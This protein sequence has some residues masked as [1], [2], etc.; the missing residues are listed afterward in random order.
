MTSIS[1]GG[2]AFH[3]LNR[4]TDKPLDVTNY[5]ERIEDRGLEGPVLQYKMGK[6][7]PRKRYLFLIGKLL[8][9]TK[10]R[11][12]DKF[13]PTFYVGLTERKNVAVV[14]DSQYKIPNVEF[15]LYGHYT[16]ILFAPS[17]DDRDR[18]VEEIQKR[19]DSSIMPFEHTVKHTA[20]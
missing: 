10:R 8:I 9:I 18:W 5:L 2:T 13:E 7:K 20:K 15:R 12:R 6:K 19:I 14:R 11:W 3:L 17:S 4:L 1:S 16:H